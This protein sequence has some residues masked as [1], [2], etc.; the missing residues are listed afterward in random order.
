MDQLEGMVGLWQYFFL[1]HKI[2][3][4]LFLYRSSSRFSGYIP[5]FS[6]I[7]YFYTH[8]AAYIYQF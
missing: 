1:Y 7:E 6:K 3:T 4:T 5:I 8:F 2:T